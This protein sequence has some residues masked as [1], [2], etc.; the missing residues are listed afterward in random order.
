[1]KALLRNDWY[2]QRK[3]LIAAFIIFALLFRLVFSAFNQPIDFSEYAVSSYG[4]AMVILLMPMA[5]F[6]GI[7]SSKALSDSSRSG[8]LHLSAALPVAKDTLIIEKALFGLIGMAAHGLCVTISQL[9]VVPL[10]NFM[11][12]VQ[13][14]ML[15][16]AVQ[17][18]L[19]G[20]MLLFTVLMNMKLFA[21][22]LITFGV[23]TVIPDTI[24]VIIYTIVKDREII[25]I[26]ANYAIYSFEGNCLLLVSAIL[27]YAVCVMLSVRFFRR[28]AV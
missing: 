26:I 16:W 28:R 5:L 14:V 4:L 17:L 13:I 24:G 11:I 27:I 2:V 22:I 21:A 12:I 1:M 23:F 19:S 7:V 18:S 9:I 8:W 20:M 10:E 15:V 6:T 25:Y 3:F